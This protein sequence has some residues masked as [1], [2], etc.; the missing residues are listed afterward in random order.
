MFIY[1]HISRFKLLLQNFTKHSFVYFVSFILSSTP[2][3]FFQSSYLVNNLYHT[4]ENGEFWRLN[5]N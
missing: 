1:S 4:F 2:E 3:V 5:G